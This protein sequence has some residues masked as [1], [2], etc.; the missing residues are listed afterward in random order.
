MEV[1]VSELFVE[2]DPV[3]H[4]LH[5]PRLQ[6]AHGYI[7]FARA[8]FKTRSPHK[9]DRL[10]VPPIRQ[11]PMTVKHGARSFHPQTLA[12]GNIVDLNRKLAANTRSS[13]ALSKLETAVAKY[14]FESYL[15]TMLS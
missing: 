10:P 2:D 11:R 1:R 15:S 3:S 8:L 13:E 12:L 7:K 5:D 6:D 14:L 9:I 4:G